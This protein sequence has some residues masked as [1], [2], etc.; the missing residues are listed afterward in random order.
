M[1][2]CWR[3]SGLVHELFNLYCMDLILHLQGQVLQYLALR[4]FSLWNLQ[5]GICRLLCKWPTTYL[6]PW[7][8]VLLEKLIVT[9]LVNKF[10]TLYGTQMF[11]TMLTKSHHWYPYWATWIQST[12]SHPISL[13][14]ILILFSHQ[15]LHFPSGLFISGFPT[16]IMYSFLLSS[17][18]ATC[19]TH[20]ILLHLITHHSNNIWWSVQV[21]MLLIMQSSLA[22][23]H[24]LHLRSKCSVQHPVLKHHQSMFLLQHDRPS[25]T[26]I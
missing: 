22:S 9:Q 5:W 26:A 8:K 3:D 18:C 25:F 20:L 19:P 24:F 10:S 6:P 17:M 14:F 4:Q 12:P 23:C 11:N 1:T 16:K 15:H 2:S 21:M 13:R 7:N